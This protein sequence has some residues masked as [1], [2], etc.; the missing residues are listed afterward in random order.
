M[1]KAN[2]HA[3]TG[4]PASMESEEYLI[5]LR[6]ENHFLNAFVSKPKGVFTY[7]K[8]EFRILRRRMTACNQGS[9]QY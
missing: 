4:H 5:I 2:N 1:T 3:Q 7:T 6:H 9:D 8:Y